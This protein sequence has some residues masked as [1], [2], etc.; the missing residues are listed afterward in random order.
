MENTKF[1]RYAFISY[2]HRDVK[3]AKWL[4]KKL[5]SYKLPTEI[6]NE[7]EDSKYLRPVFRDKEDL[8]TGI[9]SDELR[10]NLESSKFLIV[11]CSPNS[12]Q[13]EWVNNE[14]KTFIE[15]GRLDR[16]IPYI[17]DGI[18]KSGG[19]DECFPKSL[20]DYIKEKPNRELLGINQKE[21]GRENSAIRVIARML[22]VS[23]DE[24]WK[25]HE[26]ERRKRII[27][28]SIGTPI[29]VA[30]FYYFAVPVSLD[31]QMVDENHHL[32]FPSD[33]VLAVS[34]AKYPL[35]N[36]DTIIVVKTI[37]GYCRGRKVPVSF[38][39]TY[40]VPINCEVKLG[41]GMR[42][43]KVI[44]IERDSA[45][46]I[47][48][49]SVVNMDGEPVGQAK[50]TI[51]NSFTYTDENGR[52]RFCFNVE[53]QSEYKRLRIE[54]AGKKTVVRD[55]ECPSRELKYIMYDE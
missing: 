33:G 53:E 30:L 47:F 54:R 21:F 13:S 41:I 46:A 45:F 35:R 11:I 28:W 52:F 15:W 5:E 44:K 48:A 31:I 20:L 12:A 24:L 23:F 8:D 32:P 55:D 14:V 19:E 17:I 39:S 51:G 29:A 27:A 40:Y 26:R 34:D 7:F 49:G 42:N 10:K 25:R 2:N 6:H 1:K 43:T 18:P 4:H 38:S 9:L 37:P 22:G 50:V 3:T 36:L 16:I